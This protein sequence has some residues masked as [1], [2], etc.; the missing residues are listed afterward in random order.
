MTSIHTIEISISRRIISSLLS[1]F[2]VFGKNLEKN[3]YKVSVRG[4]GVAV[5]AVSM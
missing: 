2:G 4:H 1:G 5:A 3:Q